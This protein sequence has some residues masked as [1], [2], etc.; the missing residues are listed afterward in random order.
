MPPIAQPTKGATIKRMLEKDSKVGDKLFAAKA[1]RNGAH[2]KAARAAFGGAAVFDPAKVFRNFSVKVEDTIEAGNKV[3]VRWRAT[4]THVGAFG[5]V[6]ACDNNVDFTGITIYRFERNKIAETWS[7]FD[8][9]KIAAT[10]G[11]DRTAQVTK[12]LSAARR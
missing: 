4:G 7:E 11:A 12:V 8:A 1:I 10:C 3:V 2:D 9:A 6:A 5:A